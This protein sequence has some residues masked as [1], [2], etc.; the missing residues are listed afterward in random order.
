L[1]YAVRHTIIATMMCVVAIRQL[2]RASDYKPIHCGG[3]CFK[4]CFIVQKRYI[5]YTSKGICTVLVQYMYSICT[6]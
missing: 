2:L 6:L 4:V 1:G 3:W 5:A